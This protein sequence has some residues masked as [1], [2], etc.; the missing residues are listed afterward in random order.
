MIFHSL[1]G[2]PNK[3]FYECIQQR[4]EEVIMIQEQ[5]TGDFSLYGITYKHINI[6]K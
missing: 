1:F 4:K 5:D 3:N 6:D 2:S